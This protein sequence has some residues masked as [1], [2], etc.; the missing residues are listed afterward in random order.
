MYP[1]HHFKVSKHSNSYTKEIL[2]T[3]LIQVILLINPNTFAQHPDTLAIGT[4]KSETLKYLRCLG[5]IETEK[6]AREQF[7]AKYG[8]N[9]QDCRDASVIEHTR[10]KKEPSPMASSAYDIIHAGTVI[11]AFKFFEE[12]KYWAVNY[13]EKWGFLPETALKIIR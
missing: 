13:K 6:K 12:G 3:I 10:L 1:V 2:L 4:S 8:I 7:I 5:A 9:V 11:K